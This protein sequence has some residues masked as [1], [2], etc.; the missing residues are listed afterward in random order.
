M[1]WTY[2]FPI[3]TDRDKV[4]LLIGDTDDDDK[5]LADEELDF[6]IAENANVYTA[7]SR[8]CNAL[9]ARYAR[10]A[11]KKMG[12]L[13][14]AME[15]ISSHYRDLAEEL[16]A[17]GAGSYSVPSAGGVEVTDRN[18]NQQDTS[19]THGFIRR[20]MHDFNEPPVTPNSQS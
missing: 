4:R 5:Q 16:F 12:D 20:G 18:A 13:S 9:A 11:D 3:A 7:G 15:K 8:A 2:Q 1:S 17:R 19:V 14:I 6:F 10:K